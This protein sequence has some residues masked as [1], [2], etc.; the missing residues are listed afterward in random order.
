M[1]K[2]FTVSILSLFFS[3]VQIAFINDN[4]LGSLEKAGLVKLT[5]DI[6]IKKG[7]V[8]GNTGRTGT[9]AY[10]CCRLGSVRGVQQHNFLV[11]LLR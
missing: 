2:A 5:R 3:S 9:L 10:V 4:I 6:C 1:I 11:T 8:P 7:T